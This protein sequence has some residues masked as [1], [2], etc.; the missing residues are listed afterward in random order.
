MNNFQRIYLIGPMGAGKT[1]I[2]KMV[3]R[4]LEF[5]FIDSDH[6]IEQRTGVDISTIFDYEGDQGFRDRETCVLESLS[7]K[8]RFLI[9]TGGGAVIREENRN[10]MR[11]TGFVVYLQ[12]SVRQSLIRTRKDTKRPILQTDNPYET[13][14]RLAKERT[15]LYES[16]ANLTVDTDKHRTNKL[17]FMI[18]D[19]Y[20]K[21]VKKTELSHE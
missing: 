10:V 7:E 5:D 13:L 17:K 18:A 1:T 8:T 3:A 6:E 9:A 20:R 16:I 19:G 2:G 12:V 11:T 15:P 14:T 4:E 21:A